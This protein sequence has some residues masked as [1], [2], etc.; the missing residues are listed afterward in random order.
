[1]RRAAGFGPRVDTALLALCILAAL[2]LKASS[3]EVRDGLAAFLRGTILS[4][5]FSMQASTEKW[6]AAL[7]SYD[8]MVA[9]RDSALL[10]ALE[11]PTLEAEN[12]RLTRMLLLGSRL[13]TGWIPARVFYDPSLGKHTDVILAAGSDAGIKVLA[14]VV[15]SDGLVGAVQSVDKNTSVVRLWTDEEFAVGAMSEDGKAFGIVKPRGDGYMLELRDVQD[16]S[17]PNGTRIVTAGVGGVYPAMIPIGVIV[18]TLSAGNAWARSYLVR[19]AVRPQDISS[20]IVLDPARAAQG[21]R[22]VWPSPAQ[23]DSALKVMAAKGDS[24]GLMKYRAELKAQA[25]SALLR[26]R[27]GGV[28]DTSGVAGKAAIIPPPIP[29][30]Q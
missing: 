10:A 13:R 24:I 2:I 21:V 17:L 23:L 16:R 11:M 19:P 6:R 7:A 28:R 8:D 20:V 30:V 27:A 3:E 29:G 25:D 14:P 4:P 18:D 26:F 12:E 1:M 9:A 5:L 15:T 22:G